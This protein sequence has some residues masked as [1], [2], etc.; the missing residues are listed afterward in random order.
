MA[1][2]FHRILISR[3][4]LYLLLLFLLLML[5]IFFACLTFE[6]WPWSYLLSTVAVPYNSHVTLL[7]VGKRAKTIISWRGKSGI[8]EYTNI[9]AR[10]F[11][12]FSLNKQF[13]FGLWCLALRYIVAVS[14]IGGGN[15]NTQRKP[16]T[17]H[18]SLTNFIT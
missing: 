12:Y 7:S 6:L 5:I 4:V 13:R 14:F 11:R 10:E 2:F 8:S 18:K 16:P 17:C 15:R 9:M 3:F 1:D